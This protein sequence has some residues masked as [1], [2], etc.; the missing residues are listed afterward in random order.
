MNYR[1]HPDVVGFYDGWMSTAA[2]WSGPEG[3]PPYRYAKTVTPHDSG[4]CGDHPAV[5]AVDG[6]GEV[7]K[8]RQ[9]AE[10]LRFLKRRGVIANYGQVALLL[11]SVQEQVA[12]PYLDAL[13]R[14]GVPVRRGPAGSDDGRQER[15]SR[16]AVTVTTIH[17]AK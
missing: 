11:Q 14:G 10:L 4:R 13:E 17:Q 6:R 9:L 1:S 15:R 8:G 2:D 7:D 3:P 16:R 12:R 5:I